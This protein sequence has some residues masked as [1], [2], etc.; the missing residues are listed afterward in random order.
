MLRIC[1]GSLAEITAAAKPR[2]VRFPIA[3]SMRPGLKS[4]GGSNH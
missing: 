3:G 4:T 1:N 2:R